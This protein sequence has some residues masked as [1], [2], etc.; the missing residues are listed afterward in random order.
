VEHSNLAK[1]LIESSGL[2]LKAD[3]I[4]CLVQ[5]AGMI[6]NESSNFN[7]TGFKNMEDLVSGLIIESLLP[8]KDANVPRGTLFCDLGT[9]SGIP[10]IPLGVMLDTLN[11]VLVESNQ[12]KVN[13]MN[14]VFKCLDMNTI[15]AV[16]ERTEEFGRNADN[17]EKFGF[18]VS[19]AFAP[20]YV[21]IEMAAPILSIDGSL[22]IYSNRGYAD[23]PDAVINHAEELGLFPG[24]AFNIDLSVGGIAFIKKAS[25]PDKFPRRYPVIKRESD[26]AMNG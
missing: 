2:S 19:R 5:Y 20:E 12:K 14:D 13:F 1:S 26:K 4:D 24:N 15:T 18:A 17:R 25:T 11:G 7:L 21:V 23:L 6:F 3:Q 10:G 22:F 9:G 8:F 16:C